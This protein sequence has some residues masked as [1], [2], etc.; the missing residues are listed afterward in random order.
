MDELSLLEYEVI[1]EILKWEISRE[2]NEAQ[3]INILARLSAPFDVIRERLIEVNFSH[4]SNIPT[5]H[6]WLF[7][8]ILKWKSERSKDFNDLHPSNI[9][10]DSTLV[11]WLSLGSLI[12]TNDSYDL[13]IPLNEI[14][15]DKLKFEISI[16]VKDII[17]EKMPSCCYTWS[18]KVWKINRF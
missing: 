7:G 6:P 8:P 18:I 15:F 4:P 16:E 13:N 10:K 1:C 17:Q 14:T 3:F 5:K 12:E 11:E 2:V 9:E